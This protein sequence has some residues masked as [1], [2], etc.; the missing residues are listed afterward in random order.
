MTFPVS[1]IF[2]CT[3]VSM[4]HNSMTNIC[5]VMSKGIHVLARATRLALNCFLLYVMQLLGIN[6]HST[7]NGNHNKR[8]Q[9][10]YRVKMALRV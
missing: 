9:Y 4:N 7:L 3:I 1:F 10:S 2:S 6:V 5:F 8:L